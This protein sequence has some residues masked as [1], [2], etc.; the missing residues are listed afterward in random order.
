[1]CPIHD[2][3]EDKLPGCVVNGVHRYGEEEGEGDSVHIF[4]EVE[5]RGDGNGSVVS[6][7]GHGDGDGFTIDNVE[8]GRDGVLAFEVMDDDFVHEGGWNGA[9]VYDCLRDG[10]PV[11][12]GGRDGARVYEDDLIGIWEGE[13]AC[14]VREGACE[15]R[16]GGEGG[17]D[18]VGVLDNRPNDAEG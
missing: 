10:D 12:E 1:M 2:G 16:G 18:G 11:Y 7:E 15:F 4:K 3:N 5:G 9:R 13:E 8:S 6:G 17:H 14:V